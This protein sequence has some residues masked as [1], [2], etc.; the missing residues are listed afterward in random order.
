MLIRATTSMAGFLRFSINGSAMAPTILRG[1]QV[2]AD[3]HYYRNRNPDLRE[4]IVLRHGGNIL[5][6][7]VIAVAGETIE[8]RDG[9]VFLNGEQ[10]DEGYIQHVGTAPTAP[11]AFGPILVPDGMCFVMGDNRNVSLDSRMAEFG[12]VRTSSVVGKALYKL[13]MHPQRMEE[14]E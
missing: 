10:L 12:M 7:R 6:R 14:V 9:L 11:D 3:L 1:D 5:V 4:V 13:R 8:G 2:I